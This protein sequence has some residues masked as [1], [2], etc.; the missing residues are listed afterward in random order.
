MS[1]YPI[2]ENSATTPGAYAHVVTLHVS[3]GLKQSVRQCLSKGT[4][5]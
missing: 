3:I 5:K 4:T 2:Y 1:Y